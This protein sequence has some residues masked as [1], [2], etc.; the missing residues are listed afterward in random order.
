MD[1][2]GAAPRL[3]SGALGGQG[4]TLYGNA[5]LEAAKLH[6][7]GVETSPE[8]RT[9]FGPSRAFWLHVTGTVLVVVIL[10]LMIWKPGA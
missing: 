10:V 7:S 2:R 4:G 1:R 5:A 3:V 6:A 9:V 8:L